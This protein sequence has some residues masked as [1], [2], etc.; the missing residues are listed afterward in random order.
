MYII[1]IMILVYDMVSLHFYGR[2]RKNAVLL[3]YGPMFLKFKLY[4]NHTYTHKSCIGSTSFKV[5]S[6]NQSSSPGRCCWQGFPP[7]STAGHSWTQ[8]RTLLRTSSELGPSA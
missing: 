3:E 4:C 2:L 7:W 8:R 1:N 5:E 6:Q